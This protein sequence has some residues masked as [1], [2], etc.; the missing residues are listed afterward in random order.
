M[1]EINTSQTT[2]TPFW[3]ACEG[4]LY[5]KGLTP[6]ICFAADGEL[7]ALEQ[8]QAFDG[9]S[10][11]HIIALVVLS[12]F[13]VIAFISNHIFR[14]NYMERYAASRETPE[15][16][17]RE[18]TLTVREPA[19]VP[20]S[21]NEGKA[22]AANYQQEVQQSIEALDAEWAALYKYLNQTL[23]T[24]ILYVDRNPNPIPVDF[25]LFKSYQGALDDFLN[26][27]AVKKKCLKYI[28]AEILDLCRD[29]SW[30]G[31]QSLITRKTEALRLLP[32][33]LTSDEIEVLNFLEKFSRSTTNDIKY[34]LE[35]HTLEIARELDP[36]ISKKIILRNSTIGF[37]RGEIT[38]ICERLNN[39]ES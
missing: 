18:D 11:L 1:I 20:V 21:I 17:Q 10:V 15:R 29:P 32:R 6:K 28:K 3:T 13:S 4:M 14:L 24:L 5:V 27:P 38:T 19:I 31:Y 7:I 26:Y 2:P 37:R 30:D 23:H 25:G 35:D 34:Q 8:D 22:R 9:L 12:I 33:V 16:P 36:L 39:L